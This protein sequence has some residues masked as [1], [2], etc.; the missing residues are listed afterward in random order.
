MKN[1]YQFDYTRVVRESF[2]I[3]AH[4]E[5]EARVILA[6]FAANDYPCFHIRR[7]E[8]TVV[9]SYIENPVIVLSPDTPD[10]QLEAVLNGAE[11]KVGSE[12]Q[13]YYPSHLSKYFLTE[14]LTLGVSDE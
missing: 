3:R 8:P 5:E 1:I 9:G 6:R 7:T 14:K 11:L 4:S 12:P 13:L 2:Q 10:D